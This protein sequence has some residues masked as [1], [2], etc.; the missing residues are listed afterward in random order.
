[1]EE[2]RGCA[3]STKARGGLRRA[4]RSWAVAAVLMA[5]LA[6]NAGCSPGGG[7]GGDSGG[8][9]TRG[10]ICLGVVT[11]A[12]RVDVQNPDGQRVRPDRL[13][14]R[15]DGGGTEWLVGGS[16]ARSSTG[17]FCGASG[18]GVRAFAQTKGTFT[19][20]AT[21]GGESYSRE[22]EV[23]GDECGPTTEEVDLEVPAGACD[24]CGGSGADAGTDAAGE[25]DVGADAASDAE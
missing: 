6:G 20:E 9:D 2:R 25:A 18:S 24:V 14:V 19:V 21:C 15:R 1:M 3:S 11:Y 16:D 4:S 13:V 8:E 17:A 10:P 5:G 22:V 23:S 7:A 12:L